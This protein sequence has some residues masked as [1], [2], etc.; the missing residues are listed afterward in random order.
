MVQSI[1]NANNLQVIIC[2]FL[3]I[4]NDNKATNKRHLSRENM[5]IAKKGKHLEK[6]RIS[7]T[8]ST[9]QRHKD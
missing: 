5:D 4:N 9:K 1:L 3:I 2:F 6:N 7:S 8:S